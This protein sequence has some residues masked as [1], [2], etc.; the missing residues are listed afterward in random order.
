MVLAGGYA[1]SPANDVWVTE[2]GKHWV[3]TGL[4]PW[5]ERAWHGAVVFNR[6]Y[7]ILFCFIA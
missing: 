1:S 4:A 5:S 3:Y 2:D 7:L 6:K